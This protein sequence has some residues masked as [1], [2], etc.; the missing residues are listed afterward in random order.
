M[1]QAGF[2][3]V[4]FDNATRILVDNF[5]ATLKTIPATSFVGAK[6]QISLAD[7]FDDGRNRILIENI[8]IWEGFEV[9]HLIGDGMQVDFGNDTSAV[10]DMETGYYVC[11]ER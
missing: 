1:S 2:A 10:I 5:V 8:V 4:Y 7:R 6:N 9:G 11:F 3:T